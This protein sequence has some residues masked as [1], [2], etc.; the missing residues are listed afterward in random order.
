M[1]SYKDL[2]AARAKRARKE[3]AVTSK[4]SRG[5]KQKSTS[6]EGTVARKT[7]TAQKSE[8]EV[9]DLLC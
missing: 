8:L 9:A 1:I 2:E 5:W 7:K 4:G 3:E 6:V